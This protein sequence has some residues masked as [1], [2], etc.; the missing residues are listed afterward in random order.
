M[1]AKQKQFGDYRFIH[2]NPIATPSVVLV[3]QRRDCSKKVD[4]I[5]IYEE[6]KSALNACLQRLWVM[7]QGFRIHSAV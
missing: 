7:L 4:S 1:V 5:E 6:N 2:F 3:G